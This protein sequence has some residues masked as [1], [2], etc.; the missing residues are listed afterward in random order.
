MSGS[1]SCAYHHSSWCGQSQRARTCDYLYQNT[2]IRLWAANTRKEG[3]AYHHREGKEEREEEWISSTCAPVTWDDSHAQRKP[4]YLRL[5]RFL[6][7]KQDFLYYIRERSTAPTK[8]KMAIQ[9]MAGTKTA[10]ILSAKALENKSI[11]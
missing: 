7:V 1:K 8:V 4:N 9:I 6:I 10:E 3:T 2:L 5:I 11:S